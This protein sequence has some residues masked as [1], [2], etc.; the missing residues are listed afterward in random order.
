MPR[1]ALLSA[2]ALALS[3]GATGCSKEPSPPYLRVE[4]SDAATGEPVKGWGIQ[5][6]EDTSTTEFESNFSSN[7]MGQSVA[8][9]SSIYIR[10]MDV[11]LNEDEDRI[12]FEQE[13]IRALDP[14]E[15]RTVLYKVHPRFRPHWARLLDVNTGAPIVGAALLSDGEP[16]GKLTDSTGA[17]ALTAKEVF[18]N[19]GRLS[20]RVDGFEEVLLG[21][22][23]RSPTR[24]N[25]PK[26]ILLKPE[27]WVEPFEPDEAAE[28]RS[29]AAMELNRD[30]PEDMLKS[31]SIGIQGEWTSPAEALWA[32]VSPDWVLTEAMHWLWPLA[33]AADP[34]HCVA[35]GVDAYGQ[36]I[37]FDRLAV[38]QLADGDLSLHCAWQPTAFLGLIAST[39]R[40]DLR[41]KVWVDGV[42]V[43]HEWLE[44][45]EYFR[46]TSIPPGKGEV[47]LY[48]GSEEIGRHAF[49]L[50]DQEYKPIRFDLP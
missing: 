41:A 7:W 16:T 48:R 11:Q 45:G 42:L 18:E 19:E 28:Q 32:P 13:R 34:D 22:S 2:L 15:Q 3:L 29:N 24:S 40:R 36:I 47:H 6:V 43:A 10:L 35:K 17:I 37:F 5:I 26:L 39:P 23:N 33:S 30:L 20:F 8:P 14:G 44:H 49:D 25:Q 12:I 21:S 46:P 9:G 4:V 38:D 27:A 50:A 31:S 1:F